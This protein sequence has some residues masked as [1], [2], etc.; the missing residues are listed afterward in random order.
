[1]KRAAMIA[2]SFLAW[3]ITGAQAMTTV[4][5]WLVPWDTAEPGEETCF[6]EVRPFALA[7][8]TTPAVV[9][10]YPSFLRAARERQRRGARLIPVV[11]NDIVVDGKPQAL[12]S[13]EALSA[14]LG[15]R[16]ARGAHVA[17][18]LAVAKDFDGL[19]IDYERVPAGLW[20][21]YAEFLDRLAGGL[22]ENGKR[23]YVDLEPSV[24]RDADW[25]ARYGARIAR[26]A[27]GIDLMAYYQSGAQAV[28]PGSATPLPWIV[29]TARQALR[30]VP[31][32]K[33]MTVLS[34]A[35]TDWTEA[36]PGLWWS[37][38]RLN[39]GR[40]MKLMLETRGELDW[41]DA[42]SSPYFSAVMEGRR[43]EIWFENE[44]SLEAKIAALRGI[45]ARNIGLW[46]WGRRHPD[47]KELGLCRPKDGGPIFTTR[48]R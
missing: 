44:H 14:L 18:L 41:D 15:N 17:E 6:D 26:A 12:K 2:A 19:E 28:V 23:L 24:V 37:A 42:S 39:Y 33:L 43:H 38:Q 16:R 36:L 21:R 32:A 29:D 4:S 34:M 40:T 48:A 30:F 10:V 9:T 5:T 3:A 35:G 45:G 8:S 13:P 11:V 31:A 46:Y 25:T 22:H 1:M 47:F 7:L 20:P 27:D